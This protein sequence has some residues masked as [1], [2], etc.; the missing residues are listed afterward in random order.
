MNIGKMNIG[1]MNNGKM[2]NGEM[3]NGEMNNGYLKQQKSHIR[4]TGKSKIEFSCFIF[5]PR[6]G[7]HC[8]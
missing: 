8:K 6:I 1:K 2:N 4:E 7:L 5:I 3:N